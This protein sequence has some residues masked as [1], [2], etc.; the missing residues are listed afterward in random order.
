MIKKD[1]TRRELAKQVRNSTV[2]DLYNDF[3][4][5]N[6]YKA[7][8]VFGNGEFNLSHPKVLKPIQSFFELSQDFADHEGVFIGREEGI[9]TLFF[10]FVHDTRRGLAQGGL[11]FSKYNTL[12]DLLVDGLR[13]SQGMTRKN[14]LA[15]LWWGGGK[16]IMA[17]PPSITNTEELKTG[18]EARREYFRAYGRFI[19][20]LGGV[21]YTAEDVGT[22]TDDMNALLSQNR[23]TTCISASNGGSGNPSPF[24]ARGVFRAMQ[25]GWKVISGTDNLKGVKVAVQGAG[26]VGYPLIKYLYEAGAKIWFCEFSETRIKQAL[27][28]MPELTLVKAEE[29]FDLDVD[30]FAPCAIG[31]Q[32]NSQTIPRLKVKL[33]C[34]AANNIL[35]EPDS[36]SIALR[37]RG[38]AFVP[39]FVCNRMGIINCADEWLGYLSEDIRVAAEKVYPDTLRVF[40]Y[41]KNRA[42]TT[43][44]A[45]IDLADISASELH[46]L[47]LH[48]GRRI[49]DNLV[50]TGWHKD[51][52]QKENNQDLAF[53]PVLD[54]TEIRVGWERENHFRGNEIS[55]AAA[56]VSAASTPDLSS[57][58]SP[59]LMDIRARSVEMLTGKR[60]RRLLGSNH[61]GLSLQISIEQQIP[62]E[63]E[64]VGKPRFVELCHDFHKANDEEIRKQ[65]HKLGIGFDHNKWLS[66]MNESGKRAVNNLYSF[67]NNSDL[68]FK[69]NRLLD[70]CPRCHTVL[71]SS[72][73]HRGELK[74]ENRYQLNFKTDKNETIETKVFF[75]EYVLGAVAIAIKKGGKYSE[76]KGRYVINP[77]T[78]K[79]LPIIEIENSNTEAEFITPLHSYDDQKVATENGF[80]DFPEIFD[81][82]GNIVTEGYE[83]LN[84]EEVR[85]LI[86]EKFGDDK[87]VFRGNWNAD[88][89]SCGRCDTLVVAK[90]SNQIFVKLEEAKELLYKAIEDEEIKFSHSGWKNTVLNYLN[91]TETWCISRQYWWG[92]EVSENDD[93]VFSTWF[94][95]SALSLL[96]SGWNKN[97]KPQ[98][99]DEVF[100]NP[101]YLIRWVIPS[102]LMSLL[103]TGRPA[104]SNVHVHGSLHIVERQLKEIEGTDNTAFD[105]DRFVFKTVKKPMNK[106]MGNVVEPVTLIRRFGADTLRLAYLLSLGHGYQMQV[107]AS[108]DHIN[109]AKSS[110]TRI[111]TKITNIV[112]VIKKYPKGEATQID[113]N[114][115]DFCDKICE[116]T[117]RAYHEVRFHDAAKFLIEMNENFAAY[118]NEIAENC[119]ANGNSGDAQ[120]VLKTLMSKMQEVFSPICP[121][122]YEKLSKWINSKG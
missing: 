44:K 102:Q 27:E 38:I 4:E 57:F 52:V 113:K 50:N 23:F 55:I 7:F 37:E 58:L 107:T 16:G 80:R 95:L 77:A 5:N 10:A 59:L 60:A 48:R 70:Y 11:R 104:F 31:A 9:E 106:R 98:P 3:V 41:A 78:G 61:G 75:P 119:H 111:V 112:N 121:Y 103:V 116:E 120:E 63:R 72:D 66:P 86:I 92:N 110:L 85:P 49:I 26:N 15:G 20:S 14:A 56:P 79:Q 24:T 83:G 2:Y 101:D 94:S 13:L 91:N 29:I 118:C 100:V 109:Q 45:A 1:E 18:S 76:I 43:M 115:L 117:R 90:Q 96:G 67:L 71:V 69:Q 65:M 36:D 54:E 105:E 114:V 99:T 6:I 47:I 42:V 51:Q 93:E 122:Q 19:A 35:K 108:Q 34:G 25:A 22:N 97:P 28:E 62:Y 30:V 88:V 53:V 40:K 64:E 81:H 87:D 84:R 68:I 39:D 33:V 74:V 21:Y 73:V 12:A 46:P 89:L 8:I 82:N 32:V 17:F